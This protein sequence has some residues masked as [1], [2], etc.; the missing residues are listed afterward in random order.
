MNTA[1][2]VRYKILCHI[3]QLGFGG[4]QRVCQILANEFSKIGHEVTM[5]TTS[6]KG[7]EDAYTFEPNIKRVRF[8]SYEE[9]GKLI[10]G[11]NFDIILDHAYWGGPPIKEMTVIA[12]EVGAKYIILMHSGYFRFLSHLFTDRRVII[13]ELEKFSIIPDL[14]KECAAVVCLTRQSAKTFQIHL[15]QVTT[16]PNPLIDTFEESSSHSAKKI[17]SVGRFDA[18]VKRVD[19]LLRIYSLVKRSHPDARLILVGPYKH[20]WRNP[21][22]GLSVS[23]LQKELG[24]GDEDVDWVGP[25]SNV[26]QYYECASVYL[27]A[28]DI[29]GFPMTLLEAASAGLPRVVFE[30]QG[31][32]DLIAEDVNGYVLENGDVEA[33]AQKVSYLLDHPEKCSEMGRQA[34]K[35]TQKFSLEQVGELWEELFDLLMSGKSQSEINIQLAAKNDTQFLNEDSLIKA[36]DRNL[37]KTIESFVHFNHYINKKEKSGLSKILRMESDRWYRI[38][39]LSR[40]RKIW[41]LARFAT[42]K[43]RIYP[44][45]SRVL[46]RV[47]QIR[48]SQNS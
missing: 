22:D 40:K 42:Q 18:S 44:V 12:K 33:A 45:L 19:N 1:Q 41:A 5:V 25:T 27:H 48:S 17:V 35:L 23:E 31:V 38:G 20:D 32:D 7:I 34:R 6:P 11:G 46:R 15:P 47:K 39:Q 37:R 26:S 8:G 21:S 9:Y 4:A 3:S 16:I 28:S 36:Y 10:S 30:F 43:V 29:E 24:L 14:Y 2:T 13:K